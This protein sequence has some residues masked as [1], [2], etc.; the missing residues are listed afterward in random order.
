ML[1]WCYKIGVKRHGWQLNSDHDWAD[2]CVGRNLIPQLC[3]LV[4]TAQTLAPNVQ[5]E[6]DGDAR[7]PDILA[8]LCPMWQSGDRS[9]IILYVNG[10]DR[11]GPRLLWCN[12]SGLYVTWS[13][14]AWSRHEF[15]HGELGTFL[16]LYKSNKRRICFGLFPLM[17]L[18]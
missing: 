10:L 13:R 9:F 5:P 15:V 6:Q 12:D 17:L 11:H 16:L 1:I 2:G 7:T 14:G 8:F 4:S 18:H 3:F